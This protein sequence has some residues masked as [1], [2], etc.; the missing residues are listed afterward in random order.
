MTF[1]R[2]RDRLIDTLIVPP[3][4]KYTGTDEALAARTKVRREQAEKVRTEAAQIE[5]KD[6]RMS[7]IH[8]VR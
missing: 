7:R 1:W 8:R 6:D 2:R 4:V 3:V 5:T